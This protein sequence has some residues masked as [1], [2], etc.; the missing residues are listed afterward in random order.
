[1]LP[2]Y[3]PARPGEKG[4]CQRAAR[5]GQTAH[6]PCLGPEARHEH[7]TGTAHEARRPAAARYLVGPARPAGPGRHGPMANY[8]EKFS[9]KEIT[10]ANRS[11]RPS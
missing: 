2:D 6:G 1:M 3:G 11:T 8:T 7:A 4:P 9:H 5:H 10:S